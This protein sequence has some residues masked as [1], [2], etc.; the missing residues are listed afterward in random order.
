MNRR[1]VFIALL[2]IALIPVL[3]SCDREDPGPLQSVRKEFAITDF[4]RLEMGSALHIEVEQANTF[5][6]EVRGDRRNIDDLEVYKSGSTLV[7][8]YEDDNNR[9]HETHVYITMPRLEAVNFSGASVSKIRG[10]NSDEQLDF[11]LSGASVSQLD[12]DFREV[13]LVVSAASSLYMNGSGDKLT[14]ELSG[15]SSLKAFDYSAKQVVLELSG[16]SDGKVTATDELIV[17]ASGAS[18]LLY[19]GSPTVT[20]NTSGASSVTK[21]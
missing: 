7:I 11:Y 6:I 21:D 16:A 15:A 19:R 4:D 3:S 8:E 18:A 9:H 5:T 20:A 12:S 10:F 14:G 13:N 17:T 1:I 2:A